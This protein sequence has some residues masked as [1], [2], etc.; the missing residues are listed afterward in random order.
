MSVVLPRAS[1]PSRSRTNRS[2]PIDALHK[3]SD[4]FHVVQT[5][6][7]VE[8]LRLSVHSHTEVVPL[9]LRVCIDVC[10][11]RKEHLEVGQT[12]VSVDDV[13]T[14]RLRL[15]PCLNVCTVSFEAVGWVPVPVFGSV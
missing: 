4:D 14:C 5:V 8:L 6:M 3:L 9:D 15:D 7:V 12:N 11:R 1:I 13:L 10:V 2:S